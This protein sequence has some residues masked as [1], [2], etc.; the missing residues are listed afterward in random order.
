M[1]IL[2]ALV[3]IAGL[4]VPSIAWAHEGHAH[5]APAVVKTTAPPSDSA[6]RAAITVVQPASSVAVVR[7]FTLHPNAGVVPIDCAS[8]CCGGATGMACCGAVL[9]PDACCDPFFNTS[10]RFVIPSIPP[11]AGLSPEALP[12]PPKSFA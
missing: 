9:A 2:A 4:A 1:R 5:H 7:A 12:K 11:Q 8:H 6:A 10:M 3:L